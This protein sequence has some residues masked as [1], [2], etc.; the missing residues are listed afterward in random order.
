MYNMENPDKN[1]S[2]KNRYALFRVYKLFY[3]LLILTLPIFNFVFFNLECAMH[4]SNNNINPIKFALCLVK[5]FFSLYYGCIG[6]EWG[7]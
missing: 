3:F 5:Y 1:R 7:K 6:W 4:Q 2:N